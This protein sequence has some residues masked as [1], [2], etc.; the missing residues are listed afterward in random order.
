M[1][2]CNAYWFL[3]FLGGRVEGMWCFFVSYVLSLFLIFFMPG[4]R[5][6]HDGY[7]G[8]FGVINH[9]SEIQAQTGQLQT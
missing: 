9:M 2:H 6:G 7:E 8:S 1:K 3:V 4:M 5:S